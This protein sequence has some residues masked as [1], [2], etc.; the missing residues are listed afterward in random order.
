MRYSRIGVALAFSCVVCHAAAAEVTYPSR[1]VRLI[2]PFAPG[3]PSDTLARMLSSKLNDTLGQ[4]VIVDN[5]PAAAGVVGFELVAKSVPDGYTLLL[6]SSG[7]L[8]MNPS[9]YSK[10]P[11]DPQRDYQAITQ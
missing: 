9:L 4:P 11:Y 3:G 7:G 10:L 8:T 2:A 6:G 1:P 5:R